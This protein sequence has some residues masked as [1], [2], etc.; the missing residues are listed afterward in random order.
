MNLLTWYSDISVKTSA[1]TDKDARMLLRAIGI[2]FY[3][4]MIR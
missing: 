3:G 1:T 2:P 4:N